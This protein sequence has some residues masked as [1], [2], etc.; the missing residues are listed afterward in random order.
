MEEI[1][2]LEDQE[3]REVLDL[4][5]WVETSPDLR[6]IRRL[7]GDME[8]RG[9][10][11]DSVI[12][13]YLSTVRPMHLRFVEPSKSFADLNISGE[14]EAAADLNLA[15]ERIKSLLPTPRNF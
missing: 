12:K 14:G 4:K 7:R 3:L 13:Q 6:F 10:T 2:L 15:V 1:L 5:I 8:E 11:L 9:R